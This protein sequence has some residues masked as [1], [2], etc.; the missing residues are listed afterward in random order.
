MADL[1]PMV[2]AER[3][4]LGEF[5]DTLTPAQWSAPTWCDQARA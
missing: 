2:H 5:L 3:A 4:S 1:M